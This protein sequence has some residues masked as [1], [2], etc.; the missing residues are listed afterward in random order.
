MYEEHLYAI[1]L[2]SMKQPSQR[3]VTLLAL[4]TVH[5]IQKI[6][7][8]NIRETKKGT[9]IFIPEAMKTSGPG[10]FQPCL[11]L[12]VFKKKPKL[13]VV[14][15]LKGNEIDTKNFMKSTESR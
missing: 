8:D 11:H 3:T 10:K 4:S 6:K 12:P 7:I 1:E 2:L 14:R 9:K 15:T 13:F 5:R